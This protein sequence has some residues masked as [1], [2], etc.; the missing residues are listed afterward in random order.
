[1]STDA[2]AGDR[3]QALCAFLASLRFEAIPSA[4]IERAKDLVLDHLGVALHSTELPWTRI[5]R[6]YAVAA[7]G[8][9][10]S[11]VYGHPQR[12]GRGVAALANGTA[13]HGIGLD[14]THDASLCHPG[15]VVISAALS[16]AEALGAH[17]RDFLVAVVAGYEAQCRAGAAAI[18]ALSR[19]FHP[20]AS[21]GVFGAAAAVA[22]LLKLPPLRHQWAFGLAASA[23]SGVMQFAEDGE[24]NMV[25][26][27]YGGMPA[28][29]GIMA[30]ELAAAGLTGPR[31][32]LDGRFGF[33]AT[34][35]GSGDATLLTSELGTAW[36]VDQISIKRYACCRFF[37]SAMDALREC[38]E[39]IGFQPE[40][41]EAVAVQTTRSA[42][43]SHMNYRPQSVM[44]AQYSW[45]Y[46]I[47]AA[48]LLTPED[49]RSFSE[50][51]I[52]DPRMAAYMDR[53]SVQ[54]DPELERHVPGKMPASIRITLRDGRIAERLRLEP[55]GSAS[56]PI[57]RNGIVS[58]FRALSGN[59][60]GPQAQD[61]IVQAVL[62]LDRADSLEP[63][64]ATLRGAAAPDA[65]PS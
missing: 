58:K 10:E 44:A 21:T 59:A 38:R 5:V 45:P 64:T 27:I 25:K 48:A 22:H 13:A 47:A 51:S 30:A 41:V 56:D 37:H 53:V 40:D 49:P 52:A 12:V 15:A 33:I 17:P 16:V 57:D 60:C 18:G 8:N 2:M 32:A 63:L 35:A 26:R 50:A 7:G 9:A 11:T 61:A 34:F 42:I 39:E 36:A 24:G 14:D 6:A 43:E 31:G 3:T 29:N 1:M 23:A 28:Q 54:A 20:T 62:S 65:Q 19:G 55:A 46:A 4:T